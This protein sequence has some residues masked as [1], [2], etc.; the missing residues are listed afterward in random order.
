ML[1][2]DTHTWRWWPRRVVTRL[3][4]QPADTGQEEAEEMGEKVEVE[5]EK[6]EEVMMKEIM[7]GKKGASVAPMTQGVCGSDFRRLLT[8]PA[9]YQ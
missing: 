2:K 5:K 4:L 3:L 8:P 9:Y 6:K 1:D 7:R